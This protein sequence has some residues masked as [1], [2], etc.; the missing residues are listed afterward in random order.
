MI[1]EYRYRGFTSDGR[2]MQGIV[3]AKNKKAAKLQATELAKKHNFKL[4]DIKPKKG[5]LYTVRLDNGKKIKGRQ[6]AFTKQELISALAKIGYENV[7]VEPVIIDIK[8]KPPFQNIM[9]FI[10]MASF[11]LNE[12][13]SFDRILQMLAEEEDNF[14]L[15]EALRNI[16]SELKRGKSG[17]EVFKRYV[18][19]F[20]KFPAYMLGLATKSGNM[21]EVFEATAKFLERDLEYRKNLRRALLSPM[22]TVLAMIGAVLWYLI[23][24]FPE[25]AQMF[26]KFKME[27]PR[28]TAGTLVLSNFLIANWVPAVLAFVVPV[29]LV[30]LWFKTPG[31]KIFRDRTLISLPIIGT[32]I[33]KTNIE[34]FFRVF[35]ALYS[36]SENNVDTLRSASE[37]CR[38]AYIENGIKKITIPLMLKQGMGLVP[39]L[40]KA[41]VFNK[42]TLSRLR[43]GSE[44]GNVLA[45]SQQIYRFYEK[46]TK[47]KMMGLIDSIQAF[48][49][50][51]IAFVLIA[52]TVVSSEV[53]LVQPPATF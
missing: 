47:Y 20:G 13:M 48:I 29:A 8:L 39:A 53:A 42:T 4:T 35:A 23:K 40:A 1:K 32:I 44:T 24:I 9:M 26:T 38:N 16:Q 51:F 21:A 12:K 6:S 17:E 19:V 10:N 2:Q 14:V 46:E 33:H 52:L 50:A 11:M 5:W 34:I 37:A 31:G 3:S 49:G 25:T 7:K 27:V 45:S 22:F 41:G 43:S 28:L 15:K 18:G 30:Y 36:S